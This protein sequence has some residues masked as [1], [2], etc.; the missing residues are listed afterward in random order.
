MSLTN[1]ARQALNLAREHENL[2]QHSYEY[3]TDAQDELDLA[4]AFVA[5]HES[6]LALL[7]A[8]AELEPLAS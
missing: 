6:E 1:L 8:L 7:K 4:E 2:L 5:A 3:P